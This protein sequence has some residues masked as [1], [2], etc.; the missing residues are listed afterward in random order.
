CGT[1][2]RLGIPSASLLDVP[3]LPQ[4]R[5]GWIRTGPAVRGPIPNRE[6]RGWHPFIREPFLSGAGGA[7]IATRTGPER[8][9]APPGPPQPIYCDESGMTGNDLLDPDQAFF[10][11]AGVAVT[12]ARA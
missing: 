5:A 11:Y 2:S 3:G 12:A 9:S 8:P 6:S 10:T 7:M 4:G 1:L